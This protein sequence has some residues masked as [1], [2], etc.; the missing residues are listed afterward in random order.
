MR[1]SPASLIPLPPLQAIASADVAQLIDELRD[2]G[3]DEDSVASLLAVEPAQ[4]SGQTA[5]LA[6]YLGDSPELEQSALG[7]LVRLLLFGSAANQ[8]EVE[9]RLPGRLIGR[10]LAAGVVQRDGREMTAT[11]SVTPYGGLLIL[12]DPLTDSLGTL[13]YDGSLVMPPHESTTLTLDGVDLRF[14]DH[15]LD[16]GCGSGAIALRLAAAGHL[17]AGTDINPRALR[18]S[19]LNAAANRLAVPFGA[20]PDVYATRTFDQLVFNSPTGPAYTPRQGLAEI[21]MS[22]AEAIAVVRRT[23]RRAMRR[24]GTVTIFLIAETTGSDDSAE[25]KLSRGVG[26]DFSMVSLE[27]LP[28]AAFTVTEE[29]IKQRRLNHLNVLVPSSAEAADLFIHLEAAGVRGLRPY[30]LTLRY[31][32]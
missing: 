14:G 32:G 18:F 13:R 27:A 5:R 9:A 11:M 3:Y 10:L 16:L 8:D 7:V 21:P 28:A 2:H 30:R 19:R 24:G 29:D 15:V 23:A 12:A 31:L 22:V 26:S 25:G 20:A 1:S 17:A 4:I 6:F